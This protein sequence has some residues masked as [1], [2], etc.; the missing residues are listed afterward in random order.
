VPTAVVSKAHSL[1]E[2]FKTAVLMFSSDWL[3]QDF[4][5]FLV[6]EIGREQG[7]QGT[8][9]PLTAQKKRVFRAGK[10]A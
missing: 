1:N 5:R 6:V 9:T 2:D 7:R 8:V 4:V 10:I 3:R